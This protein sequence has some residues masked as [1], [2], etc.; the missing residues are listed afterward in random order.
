MK[1]NPAWVATVHSRME[2]SA[3]GKVTRVPQM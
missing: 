2:P 1:V 3:P